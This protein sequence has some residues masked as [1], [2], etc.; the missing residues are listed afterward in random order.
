GAHTGKQDMKKQRGSTPDICRPYTLAHLFSLGFRHIKWDGVTPFPHIDSVGRIIGVLA[1]Q[2]GSGYAAK[3][4]NVFEEMMREGEGAGLGATSSEGAGARGWFPA[5]NCGVSMG[6]GNPH[7]VQ[8][9]PKNMKDIL[10]RLV[11]SKSV[12]R[13]AMYQN[14][15]FSLWAPRVYEVYERTTNTIWDK[16]PGLRNNFPGRVLVPPHST[17]V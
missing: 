2:P 7:P 4:N 1:G 11:G 8:L 14:A 6:M 10:E 15:A 9:D 13:M 5:F 3:L 16:M 17:L 12:R